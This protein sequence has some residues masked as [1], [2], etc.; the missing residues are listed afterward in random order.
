MIAAVFLFVACERDNQNSSS[1]EGILRI[2]LNPTSEMDN[3]VATRIDGSNLPSVD[4]FSLKI[5][6]GDD[7]KS[8]WDKFSD[9]EKT[10]IFPIGNYSATASYGNLDTEGWDAPCFS[11]TEDFTIYD[12]QTTDVTITCKIQNAQVGIK[13]TDSFKKYFE[14]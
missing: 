9:Y 2:Q 7:L 6:K 14:S 12:E 13:Y 5:F 1:K 8:A 4:D 3:I 10:L 11:G